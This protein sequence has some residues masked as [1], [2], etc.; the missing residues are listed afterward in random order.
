MEHCKPISFF[1]DIYFDALVSR[2]LTLA[3]C[4]RELGR[5]RSSIELDTAS[6]K[7]GEMEALENTVNERIRAHLPVNVRLLSIDHPDVEKVCILTLL[8]KS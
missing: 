2:V 8:G 5:Q 3:L 4:Y 7:P 1:I 6:V